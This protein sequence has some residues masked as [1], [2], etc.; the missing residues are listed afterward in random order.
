MIQKRIL[1]FIYI[2]TLFSC[3][4]DKFEL[5]NNYVYS[6]NGFSNGITIYKFT[7]NGFKKNGAPKELANDTVITFLFY[8]KLSDVSNKIYFNKKTVGYSWELKG[9]YYE[10]LPIKFA[11]NSWYFIFS[12]DFKNHDLSESYTQFYINID[13][14]NGMKIIK[15]TNYIPW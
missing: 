2:V 14:L 4:K 11:P 12:R 13:S 7:P 5:T 6:S 8:N 3:A 10:T 1:F 9:N 15:D